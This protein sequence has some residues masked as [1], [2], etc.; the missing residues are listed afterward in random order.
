MEIAREDSKT[1]E[2]FPWLGCICDLKAGRDGGRCGIKALEEEC[3]IKQEF[4][5]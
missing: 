3:K 2:Y 4:K 5:V 1:V